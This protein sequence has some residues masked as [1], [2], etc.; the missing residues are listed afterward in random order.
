[1]EGADHEPVLLRFFISNA[2]PC[3]GHCHDKNIA[4]YSTATFCRRIRSSSLIM[5]AP[6][7]ETIVFD[8]CALQGW[9]RPVNYGWASRVFSP[10][11]E[12]GRSNG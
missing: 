7:R 4:I 1:M 9:D 12:E 6:Q 2:E 10:V 8:S 11:Y 3:A 5:E